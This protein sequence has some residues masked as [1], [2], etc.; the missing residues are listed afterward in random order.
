[1]CIIE[2]LKFNNHKNMETWKKDK[3]LEIYYILNHKNPGHPKLK[4]ITIDNPS[5]EDIWFYHAKRKNIEHL[6]TMLDEK[7]VQ[8]NSRDRMTG[9]TLS[10]YAVQKKNLALINF[11]LKN[12]A[13]FNI[14]SGD[15]ETVFCEACYK[16][17]GIRVFKEI[18]GTINPLQINKNLFDKD[19][20][21]NLLIHRLCAFDE[22]IKKLYWLEKQFPE[23]WQAL[24][25]NKKIWTE[26]IEH[27][28]EKDANEIFLYLKGLQNLKNDL[29]NT[30]PQIINNTKK[31][32]KL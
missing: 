12:N 17:V 8:I 18:W 14:K 24:K 19:C 7:V 3:V 13:D 5:V 32:M 27:A 2:K 4:R 28:K 22:N 6:Q 23:Q 26:L 10:H 16:H 15:N 25:S 29:E 30:L 21:D 11:C 20:S 31:R 1:M 9:D